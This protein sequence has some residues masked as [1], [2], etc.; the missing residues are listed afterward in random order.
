MMQRRLYLCLVIL[1]RGVLSGFSQSSNT[2][3]DSLKNKLTTTQSAKEKIKVCNALAQAYRN[4]KDS[5]QASKYIQKALVLAKKQQDWKGVWAAL[6]QQGQLYAKL[7]HDSLAIHTY[8]EA[9]YA[10]EQSKDSVNRAYTYNLL[11]QIYRRQGEYPRALSSFQKALKLHQQ[12]KDNFRIAAAYNN[13]AATYRSQGNYTKGLEYYQK[14]LQQWENDH[15]EKLV[16]LVANNMGLLYTNLKNYPKA[17]T[18]LLKS[19][20]LRQKLKLDKG[21][22]STSN[23]LGLA[24]TQMKEYNAALPYYQKSLE[25]Y[26][27][28]DNLHG[29]GRILH[30]IGCHYFELKRYDLATEK[31]KEGLAVRKS[32]KAKFD[33]ATS[34]MMLGKLYYAQKQHDKAV[35]YLQDVLPKFRAMRRLDKV[36]A[37]THILHQAYQAQGNCAKAYE[38]IQLFQA[39]S[40][41]LLNKEKIIKIAQLEKN[42]QLSKQKDSLLLVQKKAKAMQA[43]EAKATRWWVYFL[44]ASTLGALFTIGLLLNRQKI[45][46]HQAAQAI[47]FKE[48]QQQLLAEQLQRKEVEEQILKEQLRADQT[49]KEG[50][51]THLET[52]DHELTKQAL[53]LVQKNQ[54]LDEVT[55][56]LKNIIKMTQGIAQDKIKTVVKNIKREASA[57]E[58]WQNFTHTFEIAHPGFYQRLQ[59]QFPELTEHELKLCALLRLGFDT[60][61]LA[62]ILSVTFETVRKARIRLRKKLQLSDEVLTE[63]MREV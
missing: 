34:Q 36:K 38:T 16:A 6:F 4:K 24:Y 56:D 35:A 22:A 39:T 14:A 8:H 59:Q 37:T 57:T 20:E 10:T 2:V 26:R 42:Y 46:R 30:N 43:S 40:D 5:A 18:Y 61:E 21:I 25:I 23:H 55:V 58:V 49:T 3:I 60:N 31:L 52:K 11:G 19:L 50:F 53:H 41:S 48:L 51:R 47:E 1:L 32:L 54:L 17:I 7:W 13:M 63:F 28:L 44:L 12:L 33:I 45:R 15:N 62:A 9:L 29:V 27:K